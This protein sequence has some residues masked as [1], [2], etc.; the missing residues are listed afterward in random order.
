GSRTSDGC[1]PAYALLANLIPEFGTAAYRNTELLAR[2][3]ADNGLLYGGL[4]YAE[5]GVGAC[6]HHT[7][8]HAKPLAFVLDLEDRLPEITPA[9]P[10]PRVRASGVKSFPE[11]AVDLIAKGPWRATVSAYDHIYKK[12]VLHGTGGSLTLLHHAEL[13]LLCA[14]S[15]ASYREVERFNQQP[16]PDGEDFCLTPRQE[17]IIDNLWYT[18]IHDLEASVERRVTDQMITLTSTTRLANS[19][20]Q[21]PVKLSVNCSFEYAFSDREVRIT[22]IHSGDIL[23]VDFILPIISPWGETVRQISPREIEI[24]KPG[25]TLRITASEEMTIIPTKRER[26]FNMVPG[27][28]AVPLRVRLPASGQASYLLNMV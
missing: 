6:L 10:L 11:I 1:Q 25:G 9:A 5:H 3:T 23:A 21:P 12:G 20:H 27:V 4:H 2:C 8:A 14:A 7:F 16:D 26:I 28:Q 22:S 18:N 24:E 17:A 15:M 13:G 19:E